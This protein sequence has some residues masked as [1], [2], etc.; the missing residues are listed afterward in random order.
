MDAIVTLNQTI[1]GEDVA[2]VLCFGN[3]TQ[4]PTDLQAF[5]DALRASYATYVVGELSTDWSLDDLT[6]AFFSGAQIT[7]SVNVPFT[8]GPLV[9][10][11][12]ISAMPTTNALLASTSYV[13]PKPN[14]G[15]IYF[16]GLC[17]NSHSDSEWDQPT[18]AAFKS[19]VESFITGLNY[20]PGDAEL[21]IL[22]RPSAVFASYVS[23]PVETVTMR[24]VV[25]TQRR[26][27][28]SG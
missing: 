17:E 9:G 16:V 22:R 4:D 12:T 13:G 6:I 1:L 5:A 26:R 10:T 24:R 18:R 28:L 20:G 15:R 27:R 8:S 21:R 19:L 3:L 23:N 11:E 14:A 7:Y 2:N 25:A